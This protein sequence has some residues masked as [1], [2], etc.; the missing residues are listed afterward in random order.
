MPLVS[1]PAIGSLVVRSPFQFG[2]EIEFNGGHCSSCDGDGEYYCPECEGGGTESCNE[3]GGSG[4]VTEVDSDGSELTQD[5]DECSGSGSISCYECAGYGY[6][7][8]YECGGSPSHEHVR[9]PTGWDSEGEHCGTEFRSSPTRN[10]TQM[11]A[12]VRSVAL[13]NDGMGVEDC[14][15][16]IHIEV[17][18]LAPGAVDPIKFFYKWQEVKEERL[19]PLVPKGI[20]E[21]HSTQWCQEVGAPTFDRWTSNYGRYHEVNPQAMSHHGTIEIRLGGASEDPEEM[22]RWIVACL[23]VAS[24]CLYDSEDPEER[25][26]YLKSEDDA[27]NL[28]SLVERWTTTLARYRRINPTLEVA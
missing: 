12:D 4:E 11:L 26:A 6:T 19:Y 25:I 13:Q 9:L 7:D 8:C 14:G 23:E 2:V 21:R 18:P 17:N 27:R 3:C 16:H 28:Q 24:E 15:L 1:D 5:C 22:G 10:V 20:E